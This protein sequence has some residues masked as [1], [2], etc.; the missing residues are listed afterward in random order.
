MARALCRRSPSKVRLT[1]ETEPE[2][3]QILSFHQGDRLSLSFKEDKTKILSPSSSFHLIC[4]RNAI[5]DLSLAFSISSTC[6]LPLLDPSENRVQKFFFLTKP[7]SLQT[8]RHNR[9]LAKKAEIEAAEHCS[10]VDFATGYTEYGFQRTENAI[11][12]REWAPGALDLWL[13]G[14]FSILKPFVYFHSSTMDFEPTLA[15]LRVS[16]LVNFDRH[17]SIIP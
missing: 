3:H 9:F 8:R 13:V 7:A 5:T 14:D 1:S 2:I 10:V 15:G 17:F 4:R 12:Y 16:D 11:R 6:F